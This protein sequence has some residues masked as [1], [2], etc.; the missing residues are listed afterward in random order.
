MSAAPEVIVEG[1]TAAPEVARQDDVPPGPPP[2]G[3]PGP[4]PVP[5]RRPNL[6]GDLETVLQPEP[7]FR[8]HVRGYDRLQV[9]NYVDWAESE[10]R[11]VRRTCDDLAARFAACWAE[12]RRTREELRRST[13]GREALLLSERVGRILQVV[14]EEAEAGAAARAAEADA[15]LEEAR[16][17]AA[18]TLQRAREREA[19]AVAAHERAEELLAQAGE[20]VERAHADA[21]AV[22]EQAAVERRRLDQ[23]A[24]RAR[25]AADEQ[26]ARRRTELDR[27]ARDRR[28]QL[29]AAAAAEVAAVRGELAGLERRKAETEASLRRLTD[30]IGSAL[31]SLASSL[32]EDLPVPVVAT[33]R[34]G[35]R[36]PG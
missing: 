33:G 22:A 28:E 36:L 30:Q 31:A 3:P 32:P 27:E 2:D 21:A 1:N 15:L 11:T 26:A 34:H 20:V 7:M 8:L 23:A 24:A 17:A 4:A 6:R 10:L 25:R 16:G 35:E 5:P 12:L 9:D 14:A 18:A 29:A 13:A 19:A